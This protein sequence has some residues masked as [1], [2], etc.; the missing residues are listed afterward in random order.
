MFRLGTF[1]VVRLRRM[2]Y[3]P[4][5]A[6]V[7]PYSQAQEW[8][9]QARQAFTALD[10]NVGHLQCHHTSPNHHPLALSPGSC[11]LQSEDLTV[12]QN[13]G[14]YSE[15]SSY[16]FLEP[17]PHQFAWGSTKLKPKLPVPQGDIAA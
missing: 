1:Q 17:S 14:S 6:Q 15:L 2:I 12:P 13:T 8:L 9:W 5:I 11:T 7:R 4:A 3:L 16:Q 10:Q